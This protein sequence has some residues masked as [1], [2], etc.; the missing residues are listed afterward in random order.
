VSYRLV[1]VATLRRFAAVSRALGS[2]AASEAVT[3]AVAVVVAV[4]VAVAVTVAVVGVALLH[5]AIGTARAATS[6]RLKIKAVI[7]FML[8]TPFDFKLGMISEKGTTNGVME[9][10][11][12][13]TW[14]RVLF[15]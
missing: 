15:S 13:R 11:A 7:F 5:E 8:K 9:A 1:V 10:G 4:V 2:G 14:G 12:V 3:V 6:S